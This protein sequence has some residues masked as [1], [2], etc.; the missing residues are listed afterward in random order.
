MS[1]SSKL[2]TDVERQPFPARHHRH[3][4]YRGGSTLKSCPA[5]AQE[6]NLPPPQPREKTRVFR[7]KHERLPAETRASFNRNTSVFRQKHR[8][9]LAETQASFSGTM[10]VTEYHVDYQIIGLIPCGWCVPS[11]PAGR[12]ECPSAGSGGGHAPGLSG[13][14]DPV[15]GCLSACASA[16]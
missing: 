9:L 1:S 16:G 4:V 6:Q 14:G 3:R 11:L 7:Q 15:S 5:S 8:R 10:A 2:G 13:A 12:Q